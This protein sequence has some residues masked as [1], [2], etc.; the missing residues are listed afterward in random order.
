ME[1]DTCK[2]CFKTAETE[3]VRVKRDGVWIESP[4]VRR[5]VNSECHA[6]RSGSLADRL[7]HVNTVYAYKYFGDYELSPAQNDAV[8]EAQA[9]ASRVPALLEA[10][11]G[12]NLTAKQIVGATAT[13]L[14]ITVP[15]SVV[16][17]A[18]AAISQAE[19]GE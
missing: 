11:K 12:F 19:G 1:A 6:V 14:T 5:C 9:I 15:I 13:T 18:V 4:T 17:Q 3:P 2:S 7:E 8:W 10:L 16:Q